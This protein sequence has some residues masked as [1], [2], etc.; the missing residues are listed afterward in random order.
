MIDFQTFLTSLVPVAEELGDKP[1]QLDIQ[2]AEGR[3]LSVRL[4]TTF[5][6][7]KAVRVVKVEA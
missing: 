2:P 1:A 5:I 4:E 7:G 3:G 6:G